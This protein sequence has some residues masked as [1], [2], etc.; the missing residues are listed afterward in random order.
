MITFRST[1]SV[2]LP[3]GRPVTELKNSLSCSFTRGP[4]TASSGRLL[5]GKVNARRMRSIGRIFQGVCLAR[6]ST[7]LG[8][9]S[10]RDLVI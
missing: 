10:D 8:S 7:R 9:G 5:A 2:S 4:E 3:Q 1:D 6:K